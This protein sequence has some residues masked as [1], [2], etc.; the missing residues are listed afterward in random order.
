MLL[1]LS[2]EKAGD[3][4][5]AAHGLLLASA[6]PIDEHSLNSCGAR[7]QVL[8]GMRDLPSP[9]IEPVSPALADGVST[10]GLQGKSSIVM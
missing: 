9:G 3:T 6:A 4:L 8:C 1:Q 5:I 10:T 7:V 2:L